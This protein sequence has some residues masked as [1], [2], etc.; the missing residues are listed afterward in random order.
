MACMRFAGHFIKDIEIRSPADRAGLK[1]MDRLV[2]VNGKEVADWTHDQV[3]D[4]I[5][6]S[7]QGC[8]FLVMDKF[9]DEMY[10]LVSGGAAV[11]PECE[12]KASFMTMP[13]CLSQGNVPPQL[14]LDSLNDPNL[15][16]SYSEALY[17]PKHAQPSTSESDRRGELKPKLC[18][19]QRSSGSFG[20]HLNGIEGKDGHF[21]SE[22]RM[23]KTAPPMAVL[24]RSF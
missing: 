1:E 4:L 17:L 23:I 12:A 6:Q 14:F 19:M 16:P 24:N 5:R 10:K 9:T 20:F 15:P 2:A 8:R 21:L 22:V 13:F 7:G 18:R 3:V 11:Y